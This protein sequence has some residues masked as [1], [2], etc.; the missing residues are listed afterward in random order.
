MDRG[1]SA[2]KGSWPAF[3]YNQVIVVATISTLIMI[4]KW[5]GWFPNLL[6]VE[7]TVRYHLMTHYPVLAIVCLTTYFYYLFITY[8]R[9][10]G[11]ID[12]VAISTWWQLSNSYKSSSASSLVFSHLPY[13]YRE[14]LEPAS[15]DRVLMS[16]LSVRQDSTWAPDETE[17][18]IAR[19][20]WSARGNYF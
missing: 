20:Y 19:K 11:N 17:A 15:I 14:L 18:T 3:I 1:S 10:S 6:T 2:V 4:R 13:V 9:L 7:V 8:Y 12:G 16:S 5:F